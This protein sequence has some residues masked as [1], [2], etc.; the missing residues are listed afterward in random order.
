MCQFVFSIPDILWKNIYKMLKEKYVFISAVMYT[1]RSQQ[2][3]AHFSVTCCT[4]LQKNSSD[5][6]M[7][8][9]FLAC[10]TK[11]REWSH[12]LENSKNYKFTAWHTFQKHLTGH[13]MF[14]CCKA[15]MIKYSSCHS[16]VASCYIKTHVNLWI[17][18]IGVLVDCQSRF[19]N[20]KILF[21]NLRNWKISM[22]FNY[23]QSHSV[24]GLCHTC[25]CK[26]SLISHYI[27]A[28]I[29]H[30]KCLKIYV[31]MFVSS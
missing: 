16:N 28:F 13:T 14:P 22:R 5:K 2:S 15:C 30:K 11:M 23:F 4:G 17:E 20:P 29:A 8:Y 19:L 26:V 3:F 25:M 9:T 27:T 6:M 21:K 1:Y 7:S 12:L 18:P 24:V 31:A 10:W